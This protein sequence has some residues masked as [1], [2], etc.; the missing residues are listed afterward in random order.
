[1]VWHAGL[2][3]KLKA[4]GVS[5][6]I[7]AW[8]ADYLSDRKQ[9]VVIPGA[10]SDWTSLR[11]GVPQGSIL[12]PLLFL[13]FINDI[14]ND[15]G[16]NIRLFA[17]DTSLFIIVDDP[18]TAAG[19]I[20]TDLGKIS[21]WA[22]TW[23]VTFNPSKTESLLFS[24]K[25]NK[26]FHPPIFM[27]NHQIT[28]V[29]SHKHLGLYFSN[30]CTWHQHINYIT[31]K[32][33]IRINIMRKLKFKLDRK[34]LE[35]IYIAF[36]RP[37]LEYGDVIWDNCSQYEKQELDKIQNEA[38]RIATGTTK[39]VS[40]SALYEEILWDSLEL[41]RKNHKLSL[42]Y[43]MTH[44]LTPL[45]LSS[46]VPPSVSN[47]SRYHLRNS[48]DLQ[49]IDARTTLYFNSFL[50]STIRAWNKVPDEAK[51]SESSN[52]FKGFLNKDTITVPKHFYVGNRKAQI[53]HT[54]LRTNCSSLNLD[55][56]LKNIVESPMCQCGSIENA[57]HYF[58]HCR[59][60]QAQRTELLNSVSQYQTPSLRLLLYG[61][62]SLS[63]QTNTVI[64][65]KVHKFILDS[66]RF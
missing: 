32:A 28:E 38:A 2:L 39:L 4:A 49:T 59:Y 35:T 53:L 55:L 13:M 27:Q 18:M 7:H 36:I 9:R 19:C 20:N 33:W 65:S 40:I 12:G 14:V 50:P 1:R 54:R 16:S 52:A 22:S 21:A 29:D 15:I 46:L 10:V 43:K 57:Q 17:D 31:Q 60:Y 56:F 26:P 42:F 66:K 11:A 8:F 48:N 61:D 6:N 47:I 3:A 25:L 5:G 64:F 63:L 23:L 45:Y 62:V 41:R 24:R 34:S 51:Q 44:N 58:F 30:D 37:L